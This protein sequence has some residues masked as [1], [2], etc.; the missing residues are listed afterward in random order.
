MRA[1]NTRLLPGGAWF[2]SCSPARPWEVTLGGGVPPA[3]WCGITCLRWLGLPG[4]EPRRGGRV[5]E[6]GAR[7]V[8]GSM[9]PGLEPWWAP[10]AAAAAQQQAG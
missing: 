7:L 5:L 8:P 9:L 3:F 6:A 4:S 10:A 2:W 1:G